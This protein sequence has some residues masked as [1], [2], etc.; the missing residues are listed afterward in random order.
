MRKSKREKE[1]E[2]EEAKR[3]EEEVLAA[4]TYAEFV[5]EFEGR[6][7]QRAR[8]TGFVRAGGESAGPSAYDPYKGRGEDMGPMRGFHDESAQVSSRLH[9]FT[10]LS[11]KCSYLFSACALSALEQCSETERE[12]CD[13]RFLGR[14]QKVTIRFPTFSF[15]A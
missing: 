10:P 14:N 13:G 1:K 3:K 2:R 6:S 12:A 9:S 11:Y 8:G 5:D 7:T 15:V 4:K